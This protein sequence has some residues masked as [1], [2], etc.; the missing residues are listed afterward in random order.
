MNNLVS[1]QVSHNDRIVP[2]IV[3]YL[4]GSYRVVLQLETHDNRV[5]TPEQHIHLSATPKCYICL[6]H[7]DSSLESIGQRYIGDECSGVH[8]IDSDD[9]R[10]G[11]VHNVSPKQRIVVHEIH[12]K[13]VRCCECPWEEDIR[14]GLSY[15]S[16]TPSV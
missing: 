11:L 5:V 8:E 13:I 3:D 15:Y 6:R 2:E 9:L 16:H 14:V 7:T 4:H 12:C 1:C 10:V